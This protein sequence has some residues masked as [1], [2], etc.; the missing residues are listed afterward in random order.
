MR[1]TGPSISPFNAWVMLKGLETLQLRL[2]RAEA[3]ARKIASFLE[4]SSLVD[5]VHYPGLTSHPQ[6]DL[7]KTQMS[8]FGTLLA[9][10]LKGG[11]DKAFEVM[12]KLD[13][14]R[15][16]NN[17]GDTKSLVTHPATTTHQRLEE[18]EQREL[19]ITPG[20]VRVSVGIEDANDLIGDFDQ[21]LS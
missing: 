6:F 12:N 20:L 7:A 14:I 18:E 10:E 1:Q 13:I 2:E 16:S 9:F 17:L 15:I 19:S 5:R 21:A 11:K 4:E 3:N 8:G